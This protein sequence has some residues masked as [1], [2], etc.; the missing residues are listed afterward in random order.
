ME[1]CDDSVD[2]ER[3]ASVYSLEEF[4]YQSKS[5]PK[6]ETNT[7]NV[8]T[9][10][11]F[12][13][14]PHHGPTNL[15]SIPRDSAGGLNEEKIEKRQ[16]TLEDCVDMDV[17]TL[18]SLLER[19]FQVLKSETLEFFV[20]ARTRFKTRALNDLNQERLEA[21]QRMQFKVEEINLLSTELK[22]ERQ[23]TKRQLAALTRFSESIAIANYRKRTHRLLLTVFQSWYHFAKSERSLKHNM[24]RALRH[25]C[26]EHQKRRVLIG[27]MEFVRYQHRVCAQE[28]L[29]TKLGIARKE[30]EAKFN[31]KYALLEEENRLLKEKVKTEGDA[32]SKLEEDMQ[33]AFMRGVCALNMEALSVLK[34][35]MPPNGSNPFYKD[36]LQN[37]DVSVES[38]ETNTE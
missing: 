28:R 1:D 36:S 12:N 27:W 10:P 7:N 32:R 15:E 14:E 18:T 9:S 17:D 22:Q 26:T 13:E 30:I 8:E 4:C 19:K 31:E 16:L 33:Q 24:R 38:V 35:G 25:Y 3:P 6:Y 23:R 5:R 11:V 29:Q 34:R 20:E 21:D 2:R 37:K